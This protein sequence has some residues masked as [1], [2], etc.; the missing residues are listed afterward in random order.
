MAQPGDRAAGVLRGA[1]TGGT[2]EVTTVV[3]LVRAVNVGGTGALP[4]A[5]LR[6]AAEAAGGRAP[7]TYRQSGNVVFDHRPVRPDRLARALERA[8][9]EAGGPEVTVLVRTA[10]ELAALVRANPFD[11]PG[12]PP[13]TLHVTFLATEPEAER[14]ATWTPRLRPGDEWARHGR[15]VYLHLPG[16]Y[17]GSPLTNDRIERAL[18]VVAT[19]RNWRTVGALVDLAARP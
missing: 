2:A 9:A 16:G 3:A 10:D 11:R 15:H 6:A 7:R 1:G 4:A 17:A 19:T 5:A 12:R 18:G 8:I 13:A 14:V